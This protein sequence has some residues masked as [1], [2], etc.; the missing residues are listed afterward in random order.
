MM[1]HFGLSEQFNDPEVQ[2]HLDDIDPLTG[3]TP[4]MVCFFS[5]VLEYLVKNMMKL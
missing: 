5:R 3:A 2:K 4:L 1:A